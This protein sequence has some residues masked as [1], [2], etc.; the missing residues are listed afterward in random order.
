MI[1]V[2]YELDFGLV[3]ESQFI[4]IKEK[5]TIRSQTDSIH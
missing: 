1:L 3:Y 5:S 4:R 2:S